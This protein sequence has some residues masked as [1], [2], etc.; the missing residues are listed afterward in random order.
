LAY[1]YAITQDLQYHL[2]AVHG[3]NL[4]EFFNDWVYNQGY[5]S[6]NINGKQRCKSSL[7]TVNQTQSNASVSFFEMPIPGKIDLVPEGQTD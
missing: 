1:G 6:Y 7:I 3:I 2:E 5:P 4:T